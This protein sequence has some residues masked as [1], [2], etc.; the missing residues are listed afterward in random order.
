[1][2]EVESGEEVWVTAG[3]FEAGLACEFVFVHPAVNI[4]TM[5]RKTSR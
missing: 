2:E 1:V 4:P 3:V 5:S